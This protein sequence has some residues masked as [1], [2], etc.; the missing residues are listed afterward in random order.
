MSGLSLVLVSVKRSSSGSDRFES[1]E[2]PAPTASEEYE[3]SEGEFETKYVSHK[4]DIYFYLKL[5]PAFCHP[6]GGLGS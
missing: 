4:W 6:G 1:L 3:K 2:L 5:T